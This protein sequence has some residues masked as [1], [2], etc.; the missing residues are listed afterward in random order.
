MTTPIT[1][2]VFSENQILSAADVNAIVAHGRAARARHDR[3]LH[4][5]GIAE[6]LGLKDEA[7]SDTLGDYIEVTLEPG[8]A[9]DGAGREI[10][11]TESVRISED[12]FDETIVTDSSNDPER[13]FYPV[14][15]VGADVQPSGA[16]RRSAACMDNPATRITEGFDIE[17]GALGA[18]AELDAQVVPQADAPVGRRPARW[19][20]LL[21]YVSWN[22]R[23]FVK[24]SPDDHGVGRRYVGVHAGEVSGLGEGLVLRSAPRTLSDKAA[25]VVDNTGGGQMRF[26]LHDSSGHVVP[27]FTVNAQGDVIAEGKIIG[28]LA[29]GVQ[30]ESGVISDGLEVPLPAGI[31]QEQLDTGEASV[32][33]QVQP[34][35]QQPASMPPLAAGEYWLMQP[36][37]CRVEGR[38]VVCLVRWAP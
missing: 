23:H 7:R 5:W 38:R 4:S 35:F 27:V 28:A 1:R 12:L 31:K 20:I 32:Q 30:V 26:G 37:E 6:G 10:V 25:L 8:L 16:A 3:Y 13:H 9:I 22:G 2:P 19:R 21:G 24:V 11:V 34:R 17:F 14:F 33:I 18:A 15:L 29:G 36:L